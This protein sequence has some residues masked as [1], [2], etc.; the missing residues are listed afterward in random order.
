VND[1]RRRWPHPRYYADQA[2]RAEMLGARVI[3]SLL[4]P[5]AVYFY[6][7]WMAAIVAVPCLMACY[8]Y[9]ARS[10]RRFLKK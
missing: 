3:V 8:F 5:V 7:P 1:E 4:I 6:S 2:V 10:V 9:V